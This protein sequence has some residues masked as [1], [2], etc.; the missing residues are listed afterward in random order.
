MFDK[1]SRSFLI[2]LEGKKNLFGK[3]IIVLHDPTLERLCGVYEHI[4]RFEYKEI[5]KF[6]ESTFLHFSI[7]KYFDTTQTKEKFMPKLEV[8][9]HRINLKMV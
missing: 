8:I 4:S 6:S 3:K 5:P 9:K 7:K 2:I 1:R